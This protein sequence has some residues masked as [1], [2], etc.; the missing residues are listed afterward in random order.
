MRCVTFGMHAVRGNACLVGCSS[1]GARLTVQILGCGGWVKQM[2]CLLVRAH[3]TE[4]MKCTACEEQVKTCMREKKSHMSRSNIA[5]CAWLSLAKHSDRDFFLA[6]VAREMF[7][8]VGEPIAP[9]LGSRATLCADSLLAPSASEEH[10]YL[11]AKCWKRHRAA[12]CASAICAKLLFSR[13]DCVTE[14]TV[15]A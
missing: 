4:A 9:T 15:L 12:S 6:R 5:S 14:G 8:A 11:Q 1:S 13:C 10:G 7:G 2:R 3:A